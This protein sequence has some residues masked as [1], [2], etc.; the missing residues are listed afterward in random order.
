MPKFINFLLFLGLL[1]T[2]A[3][4]NLVEE[5]TQMIVITFETNNDAHLHPLQFERGTSPDLPLLQSTGGYLFKGWYSDEHLTISVARLDN[6][7]ENLT[8]YAKWEIETYDIMIDVYTEVS[9]KSVFMND[10]ALFLLDASGTL[11]IQANQ[12]NPLAQESE[13]HETAVHANFFDLDDDGDNVVY[14]WSYN[15]FSVH[16][17]GSVHAWGDNT[18]GQLGTNDKISRGRFV[19]IT[20][21]FDLQNDETIVKI[22]GNDKTTFALTSHGELYAWGANEYNMI[23]EKETTERLTPTNIKDQFC[24]QTD[25]FLVD[26]GLCGE[27]EHFIVDIAVTDDRVMILTN[28][29]QLFLW[30]KDAN[31]LFDRTEVTNAHIS[32]AV[33]MYVN[34][35]V[36][37][38]VASS[39]DFV[40]ISE[41]D[42]IL[43]LGDS[44]LGA[45]TDHAWA[46]GP[47]SMSKLIDTDGNGH[48]DLLE[49]IYYDPTYADAL[50][51]DEAYLVGNTLLLRF[52]NDT[53]WGLG[54]NT[55]SLISHKKGYDHYRTLTEITTNFIPRSLAMSSQEVCAAD[56]EGFLWCWG[57][58]SS[59]N[60]N[61]HNEMILDI[62]YRHIT[63]SDDQ[64]NW[65][66]ELEDP[67]HLRS[68]LSPIKWMAP[69][70][71][72]AAPFTTP[73]R[74]YTFTRYHVT[75]IPP[76]IKGVEVTYIVNQVCLIGS[77]DCNDDSHEIHPEA[78]DIYKASDG[79]IRWTYEI[80]LNRARAGT[81]TA[82]YQ[83][84]LSAD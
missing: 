30:G 8:L 49:L 17:D 33:Y 26:N 77:G 38:M 2:L 66:G 22:V 56:D 67:N 5:Q 53:L 10:I 12:E 82:T 4:C 39:N 6:V 71:I 36:K 28:F 83:G 44:K 50:T 11:Y 62:N 79:V 76:S 59:K 19:E 52:S 60:L 57:K 32:E 9:I 61:Q 40:L 41:L 47:V 51:I 3:A 13:W 73:Y 54:D 84:D 68:S 70:S 69:E 63:Y 65:E 37:H 16:S 24:G 15:A 80:G 27:T 20:D 58:S 29:H 42:E 74:L 34:G 25:H 45:G 14:T 1:F 35:H 75:A 43:I 46:G 64:T 31:H 18:Y 78:W 23:G 21:A 48:P 7:E 72:M 55:T 81:T